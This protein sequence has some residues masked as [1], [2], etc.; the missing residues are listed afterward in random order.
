MNT[1][2]NASAFLEN[3]LESCGSSSGRMAGQDALLRGE[4][5]HY[6]RQSPKPHMVCML[7][8]VALML[9]AS[10]AG[11]A[12]SPS[13]RLSKGVALFHEGRTDT[14]LVELR[15]VV[16]ARH[17][18]PLAYYYI[19]LIRYGRG[20]Y[21]QAQKNLL[22]AQ[23]D[24]ADFHDV[25]AVLACIDLK[26][27][28]GEKAVNE[29]RLFIDS[30]GALNPGEP[31][32]EQSIMLPAEYHGK[33]AR[34][35]ANAAPDS[36]AAKSFSAVLRLHE[37]IGLFNEGKTDDALAT[38]RA[39]VTAHPHTPLAY[40]YIALI[41]YGRGEYLTARKNLLAAQ[42]DSADFHDVYA[43]LACIDLKT[44]NNKEA[45]NEWRRFINSIGALNPGEP[46]AEQSIMLPTEYKEKLARVR[47][48]A[49]KDSA[50]AWSF[51]A[52]FRLPTGLDTLRAAPLSGGNT[53]TERP[54]D[55]TL[56]DIDSR[57][58]SRIRSGYYAMSGAALLLMAGI[59][60]S[61]LWMR[62][63][64]KVKREITFESEI[65]RLGGAAPAIREVDQPYEE[66]A[67]PPELPLIPTNQ[68]FHELVHDVPTGQT[69]EV[70]QP[71]QSLVPEESF[72][73]LPPAAPFPDAIGR[74][75]ITE[76]VKAL[77]VRMYNEGR[78]ILDI[79]RTSD[80]TRTEVELILAVRAHR[81]E[82]R[83]EAVVG[84][85]SDIPDAGV[86]NETVRVLR[87]EGSS[88]VE[89]ARRLGISTSEVSLIFAVLDRRSGTRQK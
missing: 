18:T 24:S 20:E 49:A 77:V 69:H 53:K 13:E 11:G 19:A 9:A 31:I 63:R 36:A 1:G 68:E 28:N 29:W 3:E 26:T 50:A 56:R 70:E 5:W 12:P 48:V 60:L 55:H 35:K 82:Q 84:G 27:G 80:L 15:A 41:R 39:I 81:T 79:A 65:V 14:A 58:E 62:R 83:V 30:I 37:G 25:S 57:I 42:R 44:G 71:V 88:V 8:A 34:T 43:V 87:A 16:A 75:S 61:I 47:T 59:V 51:D 86:I 89:I 52:A 78:T 54:P 38:L 67:A 45:V 73:K 46:I 6:P 22:A 23:R 2:M 10:F 33:L 4:A 64:G 32:T 76:E 7:A 66:E 40:Y 85:E 21:L 74:P 17:H 72:P